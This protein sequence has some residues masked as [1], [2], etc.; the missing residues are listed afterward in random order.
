MLEYANAYGNGNGHANANTNAN[1]STHALS[2]RGSPP[3]RTR[4]DQVDALYQ[5][6]LTCELPKLEKAIHEYQNDLNGLLVLCDL[7]GCLVNSRELVVTA[8]RFTWRRGTFTKCAVVCEFKLIRAQRLLL[9]ATDPD[10]PPIVLEQ[11]PG[12]AGTSC[13]D[14]PVLLMRQ[15]GKIAGLPNFLAPPPLACAV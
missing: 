14:S 5:A 11:K 7:L 10:F 15:I 4:A 2:I 1:T 12:T 3:I 13:C 9:I 6:L 8:R